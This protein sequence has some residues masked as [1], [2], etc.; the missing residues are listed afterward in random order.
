[1]GREKKNNKKKLNRKL[2]PTW[3]EKL[4]LSPSSTKPQFINEN[5]TKQ[6]N[7]NNNKQP[8]RERRKINVMHST[9]PHIRGAWTALIKALSFSKWRIKHAIVLLRSW[10]SLVRLPSW[11]LSNIHFLFYFF[12]ILKWVILCI[13]CNMNT[14]TKSN[15]Y[16]FKTVALQFLNH[17][18]I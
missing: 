15:K 17:K 9:L 14:K 13:E 16:L 7:K 4:S 2:N 5:I 6:K 8:K 1:M 10:K 12:F 18:Y 3:H 11:R